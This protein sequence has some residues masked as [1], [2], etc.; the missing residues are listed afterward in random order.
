VFAIAIERLLALLMSFLAD[1]CLSILAP[2]DAAA[3]AAAPVVIAI[4]ESSSKYVRLSRIPVFLIYF[5]G[6]LRLAFPNTSSTSNINLLPLRS[7]P[8]VAEA[9]LLFSCL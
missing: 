2:A 4:I 7:L 9:E 3:I 1:R 5:L 6:R 8:P